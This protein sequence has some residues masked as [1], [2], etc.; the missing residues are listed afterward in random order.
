VRAQLAAALAAKVTAEMQSAEALSE[1]QRRE[2]L[3]ALAQQELSEEQQI[4]TEAQRQAEALNQQVAQLRTELAQ[5]QG[6][7]DDAVARD[8]SRDV[9]L[10]SLGSQLNTALARV[11]A[12]ER[13]RRSLEEAERK[14]LEEEAR[15]L[16]A[17]AEDLEKFRSEFF[18]RL[19]DLLGSQE[20]IRIVGDRFVFSSEVLFDPGSADLSREGQFEIA[21]VASILRNISGD[22]PA[23]IDWVLQVDGHT[24][25]VPISGGGTFADNWELSQARALSVV[26]YM[27]NFLGLPPERLSANGFGQYQPI[28]EGDTQDAR[29]Q[30]RRIEL[31][32]TEK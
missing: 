12:E 13:R 17:A 4:S 14:R 26:K 30:N 2:T 1:A 8:A 7:L 25:N 15:A 29:A 16:A 22:I 18:G 11:A 3:L 32:L 31:K 9:Q 10:Q 5:L 23:G 20:D 19:R 24:D 21:K 6:L 28:A 27:I